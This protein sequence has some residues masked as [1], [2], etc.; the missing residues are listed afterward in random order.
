MLN[1]VWNAAN[2]KEIATDGSVIFMKW[3]TNQDT[4]SV[5]G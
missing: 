3:V 5:N 1:A 4:A 2:L